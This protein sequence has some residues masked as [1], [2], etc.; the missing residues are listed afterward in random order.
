MMMA[1]RSRSV[2]QLDIDTIEEF[3]A[4]PD[5][6]SQ[7]GWRA[8][9]AW[10]GGGTW[11]YSEPQPNL[12]RLI[13]LDGFGWPALT[14]TAEA[15]VVSATAKIR[16][17]HD[18]EPPAD[19]RSSGLIAQC[20][21]ALLGS[22]KIWNMATIGGNMCLALPAGPMT[23]LAAGLD[24]AC[25]IWTA[26]GGERRMAAAEF[27][28][29]DRRTALRPGE[30]L[31]AIE[32]RIENFRARSAFRQVSLTPRGRSAALLIG[33]LDDDG[34]FALTITA[35]TKRPVRLVFAGVPDADALAEAIAEA[36]PD[37]LLHDDIHG[38]PDWRRMLT[39]M[40]AEEVRADLLA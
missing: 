15:L 29:G 4:R 22:F 24:A 37:A 6:G 30:L 17:L 2:V 23:S 32:F 11:L 38:R 1:Q 31:R 27:V 9:D 3:V 10:L 33:L 16:E 19:W 34:R 36:V 28:T 18:F 20:C 35:S 40:L 12:R 13:D 5:R 26:D 8:G 21:E 39:F 7:S 25:V 14:L